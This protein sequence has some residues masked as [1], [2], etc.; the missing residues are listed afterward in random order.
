[1]K[2]RVAA[3]E[4]ASKQTN[5]RVS[6]AEDEIEALKRMMQAMGSIGNTTNIKMDSNVDV[7]KILM[8]INM[9]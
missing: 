4:A 6:M 1:L 9:L 2:K 7:T 8:Q 3:L 5:E